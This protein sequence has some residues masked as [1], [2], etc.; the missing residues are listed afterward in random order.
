MNLN[1]PN[2]ITLAR[3]AL[4]FLVYGLLLTNPHEASL[5]VWCFWLTL[6]IITGDFFDGLLARKFQQSTAVGAWFDI[7]AD[8]MVEICY[9]VVFAALGWLTAWV[10]IVFVTRGIL[11]DGI[12]SFAQQEGYTAFGQN[13]LMR[14]TLGVVLVSS[15]FSRVTYAVTKAAAFGL[16]IIAQIYWALQPLATWLAYL[17]TGFCVVRGLPVLLEGMRFLTARDQT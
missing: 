10:P 12:R 15:R 9:W 8:R 5:L 7:A 14:S 2:I 17:A 1:W 4:A 3:V 13:T 6:L 16:I 11:V